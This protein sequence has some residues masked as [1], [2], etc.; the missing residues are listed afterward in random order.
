M[1]LTL[2][3]QKHTRWGVDGKLFIDG[4]PIADT[5]EHPT[6]HLAEGIYTLTRK[7]MLFRHGNGPMLNT[8]GSICVGER[9]C[10]GCVLKTRETFAPLRDRIRKTLSRGKHVTLIIKCFLIALLL[11]GCSNLRRVAVVEHAT[12]DTLYVNTLH[13]DSIYID[14]RQVIDRSSD[15]VTIREILRENHYKLLRDTIRVVRVDSIP[16][17]RKVEVVRSERYLPWYAK[18]LS[19]LGVIL[20]LLIAICVI[21]L[22]CVRL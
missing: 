14:N 20:I 9:L 6:A 2:V 4:K 8:D 12:H 7:R 15:T 10:S 17:I 13:Y 19:V 5:T 22:V 11:T 18:V 1:L 3:R 16:V 21:R